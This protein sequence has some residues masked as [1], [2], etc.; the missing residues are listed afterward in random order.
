MSGS[1][2]VETMPEEKADE[3]PTGESEDLSGDVAGIGN[4][5]SSADILQPVN[6]QSDLSEPPPLPR[7]PERVERPRP[8][9]VPKAVIRRL[10]KSVGISLP[11]NRYRIFLGKGAIPPV[12]EVKQF[13]APL[14]EINRV[15]IRIMEGEE[16]HLDRLEFLGEIGINNIKLR[17]DGKAELEIEF[18]LSATG[19][20]TVRLT[21][22]IGETEGMARYF[23]SQF[24]REGQGE[25]DVATLPI[26]ELNK[27]I[28][29]LEQQM[30]LLRGEL[31]VR[32]ERQ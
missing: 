3:T 1:A 21:D 16:D 2:A 22:R 7:T 29:L 24:K 32:R 6:E 9:P 4:V 8:D 23:L 26:E 18:S 25:S 5:A 14:A 15:R 12:S 31:E 11:R 20:L 19:I 10:A 13:V 17:E 28:E 30:Q 27:K